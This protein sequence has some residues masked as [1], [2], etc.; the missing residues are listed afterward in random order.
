MNVAAP[1]GH[2][3][4][5]CQGAYL[6]LEGDGIELGAPGTIAFKATH[7]EFTGPAGAGA[8]G[9]GFG[10]AEPG[11]CDYAARQAEADGAG[12]VRMGGS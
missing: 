3:L 11:F 1:D 4:L 9:K 10:E 5:A 2:V 12:I 8:A 7:R 6:K